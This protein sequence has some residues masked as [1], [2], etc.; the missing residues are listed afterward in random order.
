MTDPIWKLYVRIGQTE[1]DAVIR[2]WPDGRQESCLVTSE[3][4]VKWIEA[5]NEPLPPD[6]V[7]G[8]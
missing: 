1:A 4:Y 2:T 8:E 7:S 6:E 5:G 3:E